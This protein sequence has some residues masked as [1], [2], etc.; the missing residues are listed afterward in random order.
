M[1]VVEVTPENWPECE[2]YLCSRTDSTFVDMWSWHQVIQKAYGLSQYWYM[3]RD[4]ERVRGFLAL[5]LSTNSLFGRYLATA[6]FGNQGGFYADDDATVRTLLDKAIEVHDGTGAAYTLIRLLDG[7]SAAPRGWERD[8]S[9]ATYHLPLDP[10]PDSLYEHHLRS[11]VRNRIR[12]ART[13]D[14]VVR[15]GHVELLD[16]F[17]RVINRAARDLGSPYHSRTYLKILMTE[18]REKAELALVYTSDGRAIGGSLLMHHENAISQLH[19]VCLRRYW[20]LCANEYLYWSVIEECCRRG[21]SRLDLGRSLVGTGNERFKMKW[22][23]ERRPIAN[24]YHLSEGRELPHLNP[25]NPRFD[26]A[27]A[28]WRRMPLPLAKLVGPHIMSGIL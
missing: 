25:S 21:L 14:L 12:K 2:T 13:H 10:D 11:I 4:G 19:V 27:R 15:F 22:R 17:W 1:M 18:H 24:W 23:P 8:P 5:A 6:P 28:L 20:S 26:R 3:A 7:Q 9:Y 16:D